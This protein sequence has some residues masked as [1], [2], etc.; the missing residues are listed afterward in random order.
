MHQLAS[1][2]LEL[3][4]PEAAIRLYPLLAITRRP[5]CGL[6][7]LEAVIHNET[8]RSFNVGCQAMILVIA[9]SPVVGC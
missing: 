2:A 4:F 3:D 5:L 9:T 7:S 1:K 6:T 8:S